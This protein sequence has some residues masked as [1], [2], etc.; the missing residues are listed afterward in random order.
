[1]STHHEP[2]S[3]PERP[4]AGYDRERDA[5]ES[6]RDE[7]LAMSAGKFVVLVGER[8]I[9]PFETEDEA[10]RSG[11]ETFGLGPLYIKRISAEDQVVELPAGVRPCQS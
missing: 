5:F 6:H 11:Y 8:M 10:E 9:G 2:F 4:F 3:R 7:L 1:M